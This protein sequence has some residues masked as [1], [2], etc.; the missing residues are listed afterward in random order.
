MFPSLPLR[1]PATVAGST[2][3]GES[4][5]IKIGTAALAASLALAGCAAPAASTSAP[6][7]SGSAAAAGQTIRILAEGGGVGLQKG[8]AEQFTKDTGIK[9]E[10]VEVPYADVHDKLAADISSSAGAYDLATIDVIWMTEFGPALTQ[11]DDLMT[12]EVTGD[13][14]AALVADAKFEDHFIGV[15]QWANAEILFYRKDLFADAKEQKAFKDQFGYDLVPPTNWQQYRD[16]AKFFNRPKDKLYGTAVKGA[17]ETEWLAYVLQA[18]AKSVV[19]DQS[20]AVIIDDANHLKALEEYTAPY[21]GDKVGPDPATTDWAAAQNLFYQGQ[22]AMMLFWAHAYRMTPKDSKVEGKVGVAPMI[23]GPGGIAAIPGPWYNVI[24]S[25][26]AHPDL[27]KQYI[28]YAYDHNAMG[29]DAPL[30]LA[31]RTSAYQQFQDKDGYEAFKPLLTTLNA[32]ATTGRPM[33]VHWQQITDEVLTP[34]VQKALTCKTAPKDV[35]AE[36][37]TKIE[38]ILKQ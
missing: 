32:P 37:K 21:C 12:A 17:V 1:Y 13:L 36:A 7:S 31:A 15:P 14:P 3:K 34:T 16:V 30:G 4:V 35:L 8:I 5:R 20:G 22:S 25:D 6:A 38:A 26:S 9:V 23:A 11:I 10:F 19:L 2:Q 24:P 27:A 29:I 33:D 18:G 28:K